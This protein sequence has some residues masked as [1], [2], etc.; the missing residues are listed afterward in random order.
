MFGNLCRF[1]F[2]FLGEED[3][4][5][6]WQDTTLSNG[7]SR[8]ELVQLFVVTDGELEMTGNDTGL[9]VVTSRVTCQ[10]ENFSGQVLHNGSE[11]DWSSSSHSLSVIS[12]SQ[13]T[14]DTTHW[15]LKS[16]TA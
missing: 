16:C 15:E 12:L 13:Q 10:L 8:Q 6:V 7:N 9:L 1:L 2:G 5:D 14:M 4:L 11:V 3:S